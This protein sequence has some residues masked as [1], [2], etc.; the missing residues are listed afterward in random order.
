MSLKLIC[1]TVIMLL[2]MMVLPL[3][4]QEWDDLNLEDLMNITVTTVSKKAEKVSEASA[5]MTVITA[6]DIKKMGVRTLD[7]VLRTV[8]GVDIIET[9]YGYSSVTFRGVL[10][11]HYNN[12]SLLLLNGHPMYETV[13]GSYYIEAIPVTSVSRI[14]IIRG[15]SSVMYGTN[16]FAGVINIIT[17]KG[18][19][20]TAPEASLTLGSFSTRRLDF[21]S[22][23]SQDGLDITFCGS[24]KDDD[25]YP[26]RVRSDEEGNAGEP[27][28]GMD[29]DAY[30]NDFTNGLVH[31]A[32]KDFSFQLFSWKQE[33][34]KFGLIP[35]LVSTGESHRKGYGFDVSYRKALSEDREV[36]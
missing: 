15:P 3:V 17:K 36:T 16:A 31:V 24:T 9:Y 6:E 8:A 26:Y 7:D 19:D 27:A 25:G 21:I 2:F 4:S 32:W 1:I 11:T 29:R 34:D 18:A 30:E 12:K 22:G 13:V 33:K 10:Q 20:I 35:T 23:S 5:V 14:E 28:Y